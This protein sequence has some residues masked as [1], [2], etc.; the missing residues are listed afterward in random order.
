MESKEGKVNHK[1]VIKQKMLF[2]LYQAE[3]KSQNSSFDINLL[4]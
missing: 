3:E 1:E 4:K 2:D